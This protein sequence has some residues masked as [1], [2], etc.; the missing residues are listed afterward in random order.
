MADLLGM[1]SLPALSVVEPSRELRQF[2]PDFFS[3]CIV[4]AQ[5]SQ[6]RSVF[7]I[8]EYLGIVFVNLGIVSV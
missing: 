6:C 4:S 8:L 5:N 2:A 7:K 3:L 1:V